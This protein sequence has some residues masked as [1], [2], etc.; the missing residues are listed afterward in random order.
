MIERVFR[1]FVAPGYSDEGVA[2]FLSYASEGAMRER[3]AAGGVAFVA[4]EGGRIVGMIE[5]RN[6]DHIA[7]LFV[8]RRRAGIATELLRLALEDTKR[9]KPDLA[10]VTV[11][12]SP[13]AEFVYHRLG[14]RTSGETATIHG[15]TFVP[16]TLPLVE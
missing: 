8:E 3:L 6:V 2:E 7:L 4:E 1:E 15:I 9:R 14:F 13:Y 12:S 5:M 16:M 11:N 10:S